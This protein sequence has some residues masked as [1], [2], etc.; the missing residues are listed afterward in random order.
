MRMRS[1]IRYRLFHE[2][3]QRKLTIFFPMIAPARLVR[4]ETVTL[5]R[6]RCPVLLCHGRVVFTRVGQLT[7]MAY[8]PFVLHNP[9]DFA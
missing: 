9:F 8:V 3:C 4:S 5:L 7:A 6:T 2:L 1:S